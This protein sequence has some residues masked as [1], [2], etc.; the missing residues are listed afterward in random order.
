MDEKGKLLVLIAH[1]VKHNES[2]LLSYQQ[3]AQKAGELGLAA[4][5]ADIE[6]AIEKLN[7][8]NR[9]LNRALIAT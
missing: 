5:R 2:H 1:W 6:D 3:G 9:S 4:V 7:Q 8:C